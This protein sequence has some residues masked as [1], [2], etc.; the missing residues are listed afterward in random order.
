MKTFFHNLTHTTQAPVCRL[1]ESSAL[2]KTSADSLSVIVRKGDSVSS[3][4]V[5]F[6]FIALS[7]AAVFFAFF[8]FKK[9]LLL[10]ICR[11]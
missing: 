3:A 11:E 4:V 1:T 2:R 10:I 8:R 9:T 5:I 7:R 6:L